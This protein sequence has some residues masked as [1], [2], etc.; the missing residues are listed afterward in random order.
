MRWRTPTAVP[1][2]VRPGVQFKSIKGN[3]LL[4]DG[5]LRQIAANF[6]IETVLVHAQVGRGIAKAKESGQ[7]R[8]HVL[9]P[10]ID[11]GDLFPGMP[12]LSADSQSRSQVDLPLYRG[13]SLFD[14]AAGVGRRP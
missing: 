4:A 12:Q 1:I 9:A 8:D 11:R 10:Q 14:G 13:Q 2:V 7:R 5:D 6:P 3:A